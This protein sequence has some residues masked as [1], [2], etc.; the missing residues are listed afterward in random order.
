MIIFLPFSL[1]VCF[2][3][4]KESSH[5]DVSFEYPQHMFWLRNKKNN[6][7]LHTLILGPVIF[8]TTYFSV[9][10][11]HYKIFHAKIGKGG[12]KYWTLQLHCVHTLYAPNS[13]PNFEKVEWANCF[14]HSL[15]YSLSPVL[16]PLLNLCLTF[17]GVSGRFCTV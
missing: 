5:R 2:G 6:F 15:L 1:N 7:L 4:S 13:N 14:H 3:C 11:A 8:Y 17:H 10:L 9:D 16:L 12:I